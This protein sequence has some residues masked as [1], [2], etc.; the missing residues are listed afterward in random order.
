MSNV[1]QNLVYQNFSPKT[2]FESEWSLDTE[3]RT[4]SKVKFQKRLYS[5]TL[6][7]WTLQYDTPRTLTLSTVRQNSDD[8]PPVWLM[9]ASMNLLDISERGTHLHKA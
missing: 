8:R 4:M 6:I 9:G 5:A 3:I 1:E 7:P 2:S